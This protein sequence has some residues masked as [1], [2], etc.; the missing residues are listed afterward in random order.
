LTWNPCNRKI[1]ARE[2]KIREKKRSEEKEKE[3]K[4]TEEN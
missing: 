2:Q 4:R 3:G 1:T